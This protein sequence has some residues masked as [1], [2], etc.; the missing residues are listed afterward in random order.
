MKPN[1]WMPFYIGDYL[2]DTMHLSNRGHGSYVLLLFACWVNNGELDDNDETLANIARLSLGDWIATRSSV[3]IFFK[4]ENG[5]WVQR[6]I[7]RELKKAV[8]M[9]DAFRKGATKTNQKRWKSP[10]ESPSES[11]GDTPSPSPSPSQVEYIKGGTKIPTVNEVVA[12]GGMIGVS[13][14]DCQKW[15]AD[16]TAEGW[17]DRDGV[18]IGNWRAWLTRHREW[19]KKPSTNGR[20]SNQPNGRK[21][22][23]RATAP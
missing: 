23:W 11:Q 21:P 9:Q 5:K 10:S 12:H 3:A 16:R 19:L 20:V 7:Q 17:C 6:R 2:R 4:V 1:V 22:G 18:D 14:P 13:E 8:S 15:H